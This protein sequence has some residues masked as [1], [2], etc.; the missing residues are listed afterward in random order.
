M[1]NTDKQ[2]LENLTKRVEVLEEKLQILSQ[3]L[4]N[5]GNAIAM[6]KVTIVENNEK[7]FSGINFIDSNSVKLTS[8]GIQDNLTNTKT[9]ISSSKELVK[10]E[11]PVVK[12]EAEGAFIKSCNS[13]VEKYASGIGEFDLFLDIAKAFIKD[14]KRCL[15][16]NQVPDAVKSMLYLEDAYDSNMYYADCEQIEDEFVYF[17]APA[18]PNM[19]YTQRDFLRLALPKF[20]D[21][22]YSSDLEG[23]LLK[24]I[25]PAVFLQDDEG[26]YVL[27][28]KGRIVLLR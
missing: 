10:P 11:E 21:I 13:F 3:L 4:A 15:D 2:A 16:W 8:P 12:S 24:L 22:S 17:V 5:I 20:Y 26:R 19:K 7:K 9:D 27:K 14:L 1:E 28:V 23:K 6:E 18:E 25:R